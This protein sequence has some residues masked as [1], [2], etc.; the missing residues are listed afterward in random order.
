M[1]LRQFIG[2]Q[3]KQALGLTSQN[4]SVVLTSPTL[5]LGNRKDKALLAIV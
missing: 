2:W 1:F 4:Q 5:N 3:L